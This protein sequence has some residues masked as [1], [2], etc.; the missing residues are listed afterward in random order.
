MIAW[1]ASSRRAFAALLGFGHQW[2]TAGGAPVHSAAA[3]PLPGCTPAAGADPQPASG[4]E[5]G[6]LPLEYTLKAIE[7]DDSGQDGGLEA[8]ILEA[9]EQHP[10]RADLRYKMLELHHAARDL[11]AFNQQVRLFIL[12]NH[13]DHCADWYEVR[14]MG[15]DLD[16]CW[17]ARLVLAD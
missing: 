7:V 14:R 3:V 5:L 4:P 8:F 11:R 1:N 16:P 2:A 13:G 17:S 9:L 15:L 10:Y 6:P 12:H